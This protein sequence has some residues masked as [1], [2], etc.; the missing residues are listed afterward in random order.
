MFKVQKTK[1]TGAVHAHQVLKKVL[2]S[3]SAEGKK[4][5]FEALF[6]QLDGEESSP[7]NF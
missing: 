7:Q 6:T 4:A 3:A 1:I 5:L 2:T